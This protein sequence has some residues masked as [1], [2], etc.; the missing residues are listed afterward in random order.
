M[1]IP[2]PTSVRILPDNSRVL[3]RSF[4]PGE[5]ALIR[6]IIDRALTPTEAE[7]DARLAD[8]HLHFDARHPDLQRTWKK[9]YALVRHHLPDDT[10]L[11]LNRRL[12]IGALFSGEYA[13]ES[14]A[15]FNP[16]I[17]AH[18]D[19][20]GLEEG[21]LRFVMSLRATGEGH[22]SS[23]TFRTGT[24]AADGTIALLHPPAH[25]IAPEM[26]P[27]PA[28]RRSVFF[29]KL[30]DMELDND[31]SEALKQSL[32]D[33]F[34]R[35]ELDDALRTAR[36]GTRPK[37]REARRTTECI[38]WLASTNYEVHFDPASS[39]SARVIFPNSPTESNGM[40]DA[41]F[42]QF[43]DDDGSVTYYATYTA[44]NGHAILPQ[45]LET[46]DFIAFRAITL[47]GSSVRNKGMALFPRKING[48]YAMISRQDDENLFLMLSGDPHVWEE[49]RQIRAP[50]EAWEAVKIGNCGSPIETPAGWLL[51][52]HGVG[53]MRRYCIG[54]VLLDLDDP[55][56]ILG[57]LATP[58]IEPDEPLRNGY[59]PNVVYTCGAL[60]HGGK[61][62]LPYGI[63]DT[64]TT[65]ATVDLDTLLTSLLAKS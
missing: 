57:H 35:R 9:H 45:L 34:T 14:A 62:I 59:V 20:S 40:E 1:L 52:T 16:S 3:V 19:Q 37:S 15:L 63:S 38:H 8:L 4:V 60:V 39:L 27:D 31:W 13:I 25:V 43:T 50:S 12:Y 7:I 18:P 53:P 23:I 36:G 33:S 54:A 44:Y 42:V 61:L 51:L 10:T 47:N 2:T 6:R 5:P 46:T 55:S 49:A 30:H 26:N 29:R 41:R 65:I 21:E 64:T 11:T 56:I 22:I 58:L 17:V 24:I 28:F 32:R 48:M